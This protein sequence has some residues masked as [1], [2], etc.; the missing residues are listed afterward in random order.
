MLVLVLLA[1]L[2]VLIFLAAIF[3]AILVV[4]PLSASIASPFIV[5]LLIPFAVEVISAASPFLI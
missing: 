4:I 1:T 2:L 3:L 5:F